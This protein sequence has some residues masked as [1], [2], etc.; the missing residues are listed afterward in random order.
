MA[1]TQQG[2]GPATMQWARIR[3]GLNYG[4]RRGAWYPVVRKTLVEAV[5][6]VNKQPVSVPLPIVEIR[7]TRPWFWTVVPLPRDAVNIPADWGSRY[8]VCPNCGQ[9]M[10]LPRRK[11]VL[12]CS[13]CDR[14]FEI[15]WSEKYGA[16]V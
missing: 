5:L 7:A 13:S 8:A 14:E 16:G 1:A 9:R 10:P 2:M 6:V 3:P 12:R 11:S 15:D 4:L